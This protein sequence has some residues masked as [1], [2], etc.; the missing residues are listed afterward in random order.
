MI[1]K[2]TLGCLGILFSIT[3]A[4]ALNEPHK[5]KI[6]ELENAGAYSYMKVQ[7]KDEQYWVAINKAAVKVGD[8]ITIHEQVWMNDFKST[9]LN[10]TFEKVLFADYKG[11]GAG[12]SNDIHSIHGKMIKKKEKENKPNVKFNE[13]TYTS[14]EKA[15]KTDISDLY[16]NKAK[17]KNKN[18]ELEGDVIQV[19]NKVMGNTW[20]KIYN[21]KDAIIFRSPNEDEKV[22]I[23]DKVKVVGT[24]NTDIDFGYGYK[25]EILG[26]NGKF[27]VLE[28][29]KEK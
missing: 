27:E 9:A 3:T 10:R 16:K 20:V 19:S 7:E 24:I 1:K 28:T 13:G 14:N 25:Y 29:K 23:G 6:L 4:F 5:V 12:K 17:Y 2:L 18:V 22:K 11:E 15:I 21:G 26:V 8:T